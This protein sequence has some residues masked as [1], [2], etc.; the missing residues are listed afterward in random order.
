MFKLLFED[1]PNLSRRLEELA[2]DYNNENF[3]HSIRFDNHEHTIDVHMC[4]Q[5]FKHLVDDEAEYTVKFI[6]DCVH[7]CA[8]RKNLSLTVC[9]LKCHLF[10]DVSELDKPIEQLYEEYC[11]RTGWPYVSKS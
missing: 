8:S 9:L 2:G 3:I 1:C 4:P 7:V 11:E 5:L 6:Q 10:T